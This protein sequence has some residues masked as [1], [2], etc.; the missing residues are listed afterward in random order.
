MD[1]INIQEEICVKLLN[2]FIL[3]HH[4]QASLLVGLSV[5][6]LS[7]SLYVYRPPNL[8]VCLYEPLD[9]RGS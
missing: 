2:T 5:Y 9:L 1:Y 4:E 8:S 7:L 6:L 3:D